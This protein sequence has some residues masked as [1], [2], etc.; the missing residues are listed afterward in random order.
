MN[1]WQ[2]LVVEELK[3]INRKM[4][5]LNDKLDADH[6]IM[7][8]RLEALEDELYREI[9]PLK[10]HVIQVKFA[11]VLL[12]MAVPFALTAYSLFY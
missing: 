6:M 3:A 2:E 8:G 11:S 12:T 9:S 5:R 1:D 7:V 10:K 4:E